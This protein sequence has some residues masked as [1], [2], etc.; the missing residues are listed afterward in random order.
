MDDIRIIELDG[1]DERWE[2]VAVD[3]TEIAVNPYKKD[4]AVTLFEY[5]YRTNQGKHT[6]SHRQTV[7]LFETERLDL[8][9]FTLR[10]KHFFHRIAYALGWQDIALVAHPVFS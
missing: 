6:R 8:P 9:R 1:D 5:R 7:L 3:V 2:Q 4:I 10:P